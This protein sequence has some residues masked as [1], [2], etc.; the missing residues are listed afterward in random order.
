M[1][2][3]GSARVQARG[4]V[5]VASDAATARIVLAG[6]SGLVVVGVRL[7]SDTNKLNAKASKLSARRMNTLLRVNRIRR[8]RHCWEGGG[9]RCNR[10]I[11]SDVIIRI[12]NSTRGASPEHGKR[13][14][15]RTTI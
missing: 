14:L 2:E 10:A 7:A 15:L 5:Q 4:V 13:R 8:R 11:C 1:K 9:C 3:L 6:A 12:R